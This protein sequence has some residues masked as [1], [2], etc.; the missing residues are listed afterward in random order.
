MLRRNFLTRIAALPLTLLAGQRVFAATAKT[1]TP[2]EVVAVQAHVHAAGGHDM[3]PDAG[4]DGVQAL[5]QRHA[6]ALNADQHEVGAGF[7]AL[8][9]FV[10]DA[11]QGALDGNGV[12]DDG[13]FRHKKSESAR[14]SRWFAAAKTFSFVIAS[15]A[16][17]RGC[18]KGA[19]GSTSLHGDLTA[20]APFGTVL[21]DPIRQR[22]LETDVVSGLLRFNP[23]VPEN[24]FPFGEKLAVKR[25]V[26]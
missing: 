11:R 16:T 10:R 15:L 14:G 1:S 5:R 12:E 25:G 6:A 9:D 26:F 8:G 20:S 17:S 7:V 24:L 18:L 19:G 23:L 21:N 2:A 13:I 4:E 3:P 22:L